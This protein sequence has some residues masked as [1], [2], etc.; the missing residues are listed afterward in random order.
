MA[1]H[2]TV[3]G[4]ALQKIKVTVTPAK[5]MFEVRDEACEK[6]KFKSKNFDLK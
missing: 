5:Y 6:S 3:I 1:S 2:V 4:T